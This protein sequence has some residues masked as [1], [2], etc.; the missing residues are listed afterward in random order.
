M[1]GMDPSAA[2]LR[3]AYTP[4]QDLTLDRH[5]NQIEWYDRKSRRSQ[6]LFQWFKIVTIIGA[7]LVPAVAAFHLTYATQITAALGVIVVVAEGVQQLYQ[8]QANWISYRSTSESLQHE[9]FLY[10]AKAGPYASATDAHS[11]LAERVESLVSQ[12]HAKWTSSRDSQEKG[13][14]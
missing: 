4:G 10:L 8:F 2:S 11:L 3:V 1:P 14:A 12:E 9:K 13:G 6:R 7:A 5:Q